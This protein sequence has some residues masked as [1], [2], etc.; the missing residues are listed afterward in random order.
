MAIT[1]RP[2]EDTDYDALV[3]LYKQSKDFAYDKETDA[4]VRL[5]EKIRRDPQSILVATSSSELQGSL[6]IIEDGRI[7]IL[8]RWIAVGQ[9]QKVLFEALLEKAEKILQA[10]GYKEVHCMAPADN[11]ESLALR[12]SMN[13]KSG[14]K[15]AWFWKTI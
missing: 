1:V 6:S 13:F 14:E 2:Y 3:A 10:K 7:A 8:F 15:Y 5:A 12:A 11:A 4:R 9:D